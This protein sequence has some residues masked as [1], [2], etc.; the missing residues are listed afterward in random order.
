MLYVGL[1]IHSKNIF[2]CIL[3]DN[4]KM[5]Q[6]AT[7]RQVDQMLDVLKKLPASLHSR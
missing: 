3:D 4:G 7:V 6:R 5:M 2:V 1:D